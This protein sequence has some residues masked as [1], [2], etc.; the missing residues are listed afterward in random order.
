MMFKHDIAP[1]ALHRGVDDLP[2][3]DLGAGS[4]LQLLQVDLLQ[5]MW[6]VRNRFLPGTEVV[7]HRHTGPVYAFTHSGSWKYVEYPEVNRAGSFLFEPAGSIH[8]LVVPS[9][10][11]EDTYATFVIHGANLNLDEDDNVVSVYDAGS[12]LRFYL[13]ECETLRCPRPDVIG[14]P[15]VTEGITRA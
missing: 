3:V 4:Y 15:S 2:W 6:I 13:S 10:N 11:A 12:V 8:T 9:D 7:R 1:L 14:A 5:G